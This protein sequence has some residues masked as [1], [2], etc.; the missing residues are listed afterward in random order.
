[1]TNNRTIDEI[2]NKIANGEANIYTAEEFKKLIKK[3]ETPSFDEVDVVTGDCVIYSKWIEVT[4][5]H[6]LRDKNNL[7]GHK[8]HKNDHAEK[9][10]LA[11]EVK[12]SEAVACD[13]TGY[14]LHNGTADVDKQGIA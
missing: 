9:N 7:R 1:M 10:I 13:G 11:L 2:N 4:E 8:N 6:I 14:Y 5:E 12:S 3:D